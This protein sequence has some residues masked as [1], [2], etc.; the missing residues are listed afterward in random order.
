MNWLD[1]VFITLIGWNAWIGLKTGLVAGASRLIGVLAGFAAALSFY[2]PLADAVNLK[3]NL[4]SVISKWMF[5]GGNKSGGG[6]LKAPGSPDLFYPGPA[7]P[8]I[9]KGLSVIG[10]SLSR[11][12][13]STILDIAC[14]IIILMFVS[15]TISLLGVLAG[16]LFRVF[17][18]GPV[19]RLG[20]TA[21]GAA[22][23]CVLSSVVVALAVSAQIPAL[24]LSGG[25][26]TTFLS[27]AL[28]KS[29]LAPY[30]LKGLEYLK[31]NFPGW[32]M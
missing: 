2:Q 30:F 29:V 23:G 4:V 5:S 18:L 6:P 20:G 28:Q 17:F 12:L 14:F 1:I 13:A 7:E 11:V 31:I 8:G 22:K 21:L 10:E 16:K 15:G 9:F 27:L 26:N 19:D 24:F 32:I 3:W 25:K